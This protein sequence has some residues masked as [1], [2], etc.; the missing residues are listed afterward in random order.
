MKVSLGFLPRHEKCQPG[1][2]NLNVY[3]SETRLEFYRNEANYSIY[4]I[5]IYVQPD[6][7]PDGV[8]LYMLHIVGVGLMEFLLQRHFQKLI[9]Y[10]AHFAY[11]L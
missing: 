4:N 9:V 3:E 5:V 2:S 6:K 10:S 8:Q 1:L 7:K 11:C